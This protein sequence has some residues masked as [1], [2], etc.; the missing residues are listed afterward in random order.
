MSTKSADER[1]AARPEGTAGSG[2]LSMCFGLLFFLGF[3]LL[4]TQVLVTLYVRSTVEAAASDAARIL[5]SAAVDEGAAGADLARP[6]GSGAPDLIG[7]TTA[8]R[9]AA[10]RVHE[11]LGNRATL[12]VVRIDVA[13][14]LVEVEVTLPRPRLLLGGGTLGG[15]TIAQRASVRLER[16]Q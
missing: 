8:E 7:L 13:E 3:L 6:G 1:G 9:D 2:L 16:L 10:E 11:L 14:S 5:A 12:R 15:D 4:A